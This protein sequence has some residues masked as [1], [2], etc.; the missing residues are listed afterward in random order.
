MV[1]PLHCEREQT[2]L[3]RDWQAPKFESWR[4]RSPRRPADLDPSLSFSPGYWQSQRRLYYRQIFHVP[5]FTPDRHGWTSTQ[6][7]EAG[8]E[9][10]LRMAEKLVGKIS[11]FKDGDRRIVFL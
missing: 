6:A 1:V 4:Y 7:A 5:R 11:E 9:G 10:M 8:R 2:D 3:A